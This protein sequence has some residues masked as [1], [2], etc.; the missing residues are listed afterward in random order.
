M[1]PFLMFPSRRTVPCHCRYG[2]SPFSPARRLPTE[3]DSSFANRQTLQHSNL[4]TF[5]QT[6]PLRIRIYE[7]SAD[8]SF[9]IRTSKTRH[10]KSFRIRICEKSGGGGPL[11]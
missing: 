4:P 10:L 6:N 5:P 3:S 8:N 9:R 1:L 2:S 7:K 11:F